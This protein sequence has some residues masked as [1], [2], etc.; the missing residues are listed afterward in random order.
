MDRGLE[1]DAILEVAGVTKKFSGLVALSNVDLQV[2]NGEILGLI[3]PNGSGKTTLF[4][5]ISGCLHPNGGRITFNGHDIAGLPAHKVC[6][7]GVARTFQIPQPFPDMSVIDNIRVAYLFGRSKN[8]RSKLGDPENVCKLV[9]LDSK[10]DVLAR[11]LTVSEKKRLEVGRALAT[12]PTLL[13]FDEFAAG[14]T[15]Q[16]SKWATEFVKAL[17]DSYG[18]TI[19]WTEHVMRVIMSAVDR[20]VVLDHGVKIAEGTPQEIVKSEQVL[21]VYLGRSRG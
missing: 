8:A 14:L 11:S 6:K 16:E 2:F 15:A 12:S 18:L 21:S 10:S 4:N 5:V 3:G 9:V 19:V 1:K 17:R 7:L 13:L 20:V